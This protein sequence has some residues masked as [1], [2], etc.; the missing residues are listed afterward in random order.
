[1]AVERHV[2]A[3]IP[4]DDLVADRSRRTPLKGRPGSAWDVARAALYLA[5]EDAAFVTGT[6][7]TVDGGQS[8]IRGMRAGLSVEKCSVMNV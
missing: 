2:E 4:R 8:L 1:M 7:I 3:G 6:S 5:S